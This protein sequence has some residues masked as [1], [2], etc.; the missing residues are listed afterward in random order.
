VKIIRVHIP[1][2]PNEFNQFIDVIPEGALRKNRPTNGTKH[3]VKPA[4]NH[5]Q[6]RT[7]TT[8]VYALRFDYSSALLFTSCRPLK[9][10]SETC[11]NNCQA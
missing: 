2:P 1:R 4:A 6:I 3:V 9:I 11:S 8:E 10:V 7:G 5:Q